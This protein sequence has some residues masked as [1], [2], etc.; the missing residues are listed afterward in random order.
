MVANQNGYLICSKTMHTVTS[1]NDI[2]PI[3]DGPTA[4]IVVASVAESYN[5]CHHR[6]LVDSCLR[7]ADN[8]RLQ[9]V[10]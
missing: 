3:D 2:Q 5:S 8:S 7:S 4:V 6:V 1:C 10:K 9:M